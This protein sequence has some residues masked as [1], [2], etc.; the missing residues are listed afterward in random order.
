M[1]NYFHLR[2][3]ANGPDEEPPAPVNSN[4][5]GPIKKKH[6]R[7]VAKK[8]ME[9]SAQLQRAHT[10]LEEPSRDSTWTMRKSFIVKTQKSQ[11][12]KERKNTKSK[13]SKQKTE[14]FGFLLMMMM[15]W[16]NFFKPFLTLLLSLLLLIL[17][18]SSFLLF[19]LIL[20]LQCVLLCS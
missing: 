8:L 7:Q 2:Q 13:L 15:M 3:I 11:E 16:S 19:L 6:N 9:I 18:S 20:L 5:K 17:I 12:R 1:Q 14:S 10:K 4:K